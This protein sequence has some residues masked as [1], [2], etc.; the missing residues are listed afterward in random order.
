MKEPTTDL[1]Q[2]FWWY[3]LDEYRAEVRDKASSGR[4]RAAAWWLDA[5]GIMDSEKFMN[6]YTTTIFSTIYTPYSIGD[7]DRLWSQMKTCAHECQ[8]VF[9][10]RYDTPLK[11][12]VKYLTSTTDRAHYEANAYRCDLELDF[13]RF[14][15][16]HDDRPYHLAQKL[17]AYGCDSGDR[18]FVRAYL[19]ASLDTV[20]QGGIIS[21]ASQTAITW[22]E[23]HAQEI[24]R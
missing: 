11:F 13:W 15:M 8:H 4:M 21:E 3:M 12:A 10:S 9:Q 22:L 20:R 6:N 2:S 7:G 17:K 1:C 23:Q 19:E 5:L 18:E 14:G 24:K 16:V